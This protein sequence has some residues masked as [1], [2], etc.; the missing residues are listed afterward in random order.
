MAVLSGVQAKTYLFI[1]VL[2][3]VPMQQA[4]QLKLL[5][6]QPVLLLLQLQ[7]VMAMLVEKL[8]DKSQVLT[9]AL[10]TVKA[11]LRKPLMQLLM[12]SIC[13]FVR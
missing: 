6:A 5:T 1:M 10:L 3:L 4:M 11:M 12:P 2:T 8:V 13:Q 7:L 9:S